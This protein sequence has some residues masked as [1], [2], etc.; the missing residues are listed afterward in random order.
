MNLCESKE[1]STDEGDMTSSKLK[2]LSGDGTKEVEDHHDENSPN[3]NTAQC[4]VWNVLLSV[5]DK[6]N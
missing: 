4:K 2:E 6:T 1:S 3:N 5:C